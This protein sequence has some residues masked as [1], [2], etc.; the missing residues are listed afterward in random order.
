MGQHVIAR[1]EDI[2]PGA[3]KIVK[4]EGREVGV[5]NLKGTYYAV[6]N[7]CP[8]QGARV[9]LGRVSGTTLPSKVHEYTYGLA[10]QISAAPGTAGST[11]STGRSVFDPNVKLVSYPVA[12]EE[13]QI[14]GDDIENQTNETPRN[15]RAGH[16]ESK[17]FESGFSRRSRQRPGVPAATARTPKSVSPL[18]S[19]FSRGLLI[20]MWYRHAAAPSAWVETRLTGAPR[21]RS[22]S[23]CSQVQA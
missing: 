21:T 7:V 14:P 8:H 16:Q 2:P 20:S 9:C 19:S 4:V 15:G 5:F 18:W 3:R 22:K 13:D 10:G 6:K 1:T 11:T 12:V 17:T 23:W